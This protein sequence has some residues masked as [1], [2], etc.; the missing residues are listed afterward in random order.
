[1]P[2]KPHR[3]KQHGDV[4]HKF[5]LETITL[6]RRV[7][8]TDEEIAAELGCSTD[9]L[10]R[11]KKADP[12]FK[13]AY[14]AGTNRGKVSIRKML[15]KLASEGNVAAAIWLSKNYLGMREP[16][17]QLTG[18]NDGPIKHED[19]GM[20]L[21]KLSTE[22]ILQLRKLREKASSGEKA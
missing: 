15:F 20:D 21:S 17:T 6:L 10:G 5:D 4:T 8:C 2:P 7:H 3:K 18:A 11:R 19:V 1:M 9:T 13:A 22:D 14:D 12:A 16:P